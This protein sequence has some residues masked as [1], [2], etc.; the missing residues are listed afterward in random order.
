M[1]IVETEIARERVNGRIKTDAILI[2]S[3]ISSALSKKA[4]ASFNEQIKEL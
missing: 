1:L 4:A 3:A 2:Q